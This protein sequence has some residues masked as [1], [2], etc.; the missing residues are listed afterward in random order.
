MSELI[1][2][3]F[4]DIGAGVEGGVDVVYWVDVSYSVIGVGFEIDEVVFEEFHS[5]N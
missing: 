4:C 5:G 2:V 1:E 3:L